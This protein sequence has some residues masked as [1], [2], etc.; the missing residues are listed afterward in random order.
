MNVLR[1]LAPLVLI[2]AR[3]DAGAWPLPEGDSHLSFSVE[4]DRGDGTGLYS[5]LYVEHGLGGGRTAGVDLGLSETDANKALAFLRWHDRPG[6]G[7][8]TR[9][10][11]EIGIGMVDEQ[12]A[13]RPGVSVGRG[14]ELGQNAGWVALDARA[15]VFEELEGRLEMDLT[16]GADTG[17]DDKW[18]VQVQMAAPGDASPYVK[19]AP[20]Y[21]FE[22]SGG[23]HILLGVTAGIVGFDDVKL[24]LGLWQGF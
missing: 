4:G 9:L 16:V 24:N 5:T 12:A 23:R 3:A 10:A 2:A 11:Y 17:A 14:M 21:A 1:I 19:L 18:L 6:D 7:A 20:S 15:V 22:R 8:A 13:L